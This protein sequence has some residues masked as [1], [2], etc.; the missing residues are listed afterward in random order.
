M[1]EKA[2]RDQSGRKKQNRSAKAVAAKKLRVVN[3]RKTQ[4]EIVGVPYKKHVKLAAAAAQLTGESCDHLFVPPSHLYVLRRSDA[5]HI[6]KIGRSCNPAARAKHLGESHCFKVECL[7][8]FDQAGARELEV[9]KR[10][11]EYRVCGGAGREWF[12]APLELIT[13]TIH[14]VLGNYE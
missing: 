1:P 8:S 11:E 12:E 3:N 14:E 7:L 5:H 2:R 9:H 13:K 10:L 4:C 6:F